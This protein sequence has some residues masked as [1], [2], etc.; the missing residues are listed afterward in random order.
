MRRVK[1]LLVFSFVLLPA[2]TF[3]QQELKVMSY[4]IRLD[5]ASDGENR[6]EMR[7]DKVAGLLNYY[8]AD[9]IGAQEVLHHQL[10]YLLENMH[11]YNHI[12]VA[13]DDGKMAGEYSCIFYKKDLYHIVQEGTFWLSPT[14]EIPSKGWDAALNRV[15]TFGLFSHKKNKQ[16]IW[17][18]N[19]HFDHIGKTARLESAKLIIEKINT[20]NK[21]KNY[22]VILIGDFNSTPEEP[23]AQ[24]ILSQM[25]N[26]REVSIENP[27]GPAVTWNGFQ[28]DKTPERVIDYIFINKTKKL[29]VRKFATL[30]DSY[31]K[32][33]PSDHF[34]I[35]ATLDLYK[36]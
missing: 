2:M 36:K 27:Y 14:P 15:C 32:K 22:P 23:P 1:Y 16:L 35:L 13:R 20:L 34:P 10:T 4:N 11:K 17:V 30:T 28:F 24:F 33:Y 18:L 31:Q 21:G 19:T 29:K 26:S 6:W 12:G 25:K 8:E 3:A 7:K 5:V 9:F